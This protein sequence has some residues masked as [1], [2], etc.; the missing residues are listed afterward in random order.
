MNHDVDYEIYQ[1]INEQITSYMPFKEFLKEKHLTFKEGERQALQFQA[2]YRNLLSKY[3]ISDVT[4]VSICLGLMQEL[5][6]S[7][8]NETL[9]YLYICTVTDI[10]ILN[11]I[12]APE[13]AV[14]QLVRNYL[15]Q[16]ERITEFQNF[17]QN[18]ITYRKK[19]KTLKPHFKK[20]IMI[21]NLDCSQEAECLYKMALQHKFLSMENDI[22]YDNLH[23][24]L[25]LLNSDEI[26]Q[27]LKPYIIF[28]VLSRKHGLIQKRE[29]FI[30]NISAAFTYQEY[31]IYT[32]NGKNFRNYKSYIELYEQLR[33]FYLQ[34]PE[35]DIGFC[36]FC[37]A[38]LSALNEWYYQYCE[39]NEE[40]PMNL[41]QKVCSL[42]SLCF[43]VLY[44]YYLY[45]DTEFDTFQETFPKIY[46]KWEKAV[47]PAIIQKILTELCRQQDISAFVEQL[48]HGKEYQKFAELFLYQNAEDMLQKQM[49]DITDILIKK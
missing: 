29:N 10:G 25:M 41:K 9:Q 32:D 45:S 38:E 4:P 8:E 30:P 48:P 40:I 37:F 17:M 12:T 42:K 21:Q 47:T 5:T 20:E 3:Q 2:H 44:P 24:L 15:E 16:L 1:Y 43:P 39:P 49:I 22:Y 18:Y 36:D 28:A 14:E 7:P 35:T 34:M 11:P 19:Y 13:Q 27:S 23:T 26:L 31:H 6:K 46:R 33:R